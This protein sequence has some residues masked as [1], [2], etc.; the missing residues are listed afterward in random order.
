VIIDVTIETR[1]ARHTAEV[2][3][4]L[5]ADGLAPKRLDARGLSQVAYEGGG[6]PIPSRPGPLT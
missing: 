2:F 4:A 3:D 1:D 6:P 5:A